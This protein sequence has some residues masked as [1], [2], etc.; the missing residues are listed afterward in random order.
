MLSLLQASFKR[1]DRKLRNSFGMDISTPS[2][3]F[4]SHIHASVFDHAFLRLMWANLSEIAPG[5]WR[6]NQP[7]P[8]RIRRYAD[9]GVKTIINLRGATP[10]SFYLFERDACERLGIQLIDAQIYAY[11]ASRKEELVN[12]VDALKSVQTPFLMHCKSG[13]DR[14]GMAS[15]LWLMI[16]NGDSLDKA[17]RQLSLKH[18][19]LKSSSAGIVDHFFDLWAARNAQSPISIDDWIRTEYDP[20]SLTDSFAELR[21]RK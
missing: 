12:L 14:A 18:L 6:S 15:M 8:A 4:A 20:A 1:I 7:G 11:R 9:M 17:R 21:K 13:S 10:W 2:G 5:V 19:H 16:V 3:R